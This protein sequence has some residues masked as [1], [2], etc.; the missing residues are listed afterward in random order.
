[1][2]RD[3]RHPLLDRTHSIR[4]RPTGTSFSISSPTERTTVA[5]VVESSV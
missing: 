4:D 5:E 2:S 1:M 3:M